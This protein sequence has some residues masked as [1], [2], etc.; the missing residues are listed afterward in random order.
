MYV[1]FYTFSVQVVRQVSTGD[2]VLTEVVLSGSGKML[3]AGGSSGCVRSF[4]FPLTEAGEF[5]EH[6]AHSTPVT[7][8]SE[9]V[10]SHKRAG[11]MY[12]HNEQTLADPRTNAITSNAAVIL[13]K[14]TYM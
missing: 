10:I 13:Q 9:H 12:M 6:Q 1:F 2:V 8:V 14:T 7:R 5:T 11:Y 3:F 4:K